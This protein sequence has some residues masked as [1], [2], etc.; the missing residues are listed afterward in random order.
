MVANQPVIITYTVT[1]T[2]R[3]FRDASLKPDRLHWTIMPDPAKWSLTC[4]NK[5]VLEAPSIAKSV[6][7]KVTAQPLQGGYCYPPCCVVDLEKVGVG[8]ES[9]EH[10]RKVEKV[11]LT[12]A[13]CYCVNQWAFIEVADD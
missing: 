7:F 6:S 8:G 9:V 2:T 4:G 10:V 5:G 12:E 3:G 13:Q 11:R 1:N